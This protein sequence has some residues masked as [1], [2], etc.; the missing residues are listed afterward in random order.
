MKFRILIIIEHF[1]YNQILV[2]D[3]FCFVIKAQKLNSVGLTGHS[4]FGVPSIMGIHCTQKTYSRI[5]AKKRAC[6]Y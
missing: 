3:S 4:P 5:S 1:F 6:Y 2:F